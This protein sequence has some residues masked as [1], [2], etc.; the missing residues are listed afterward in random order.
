MRRLSILVILIIFIMSCGAEKPVVNRQYK[1]ADGNFEMTGQQILS[2]FYHPNYSSWFVEEYESYTPKPEV[3]TEL[4]K[5]LKGVKIEVFFGS[6]CGD[7]RYH[8]PHFMKILHEAGVNKAYYK[9]Y[10]V[11]RKKESFYGEEQGRHILYVPTFIFINNKNVTGEPAEIN[12]IIESPVEDTLEEDM[13]K[14]LKGENYIPNY[15]F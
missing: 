1:D 9:L 11:N 5:L 14:I 2:G 10:A 6:W 7:S 13:L 4:K 12:R 3:I 15:Y 8:V